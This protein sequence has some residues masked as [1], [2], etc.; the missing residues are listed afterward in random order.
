MQR[1]EYGAAGPPILPTSTQR[2]SSSKYRDQPAIAGSWVGSCVLSLLIAVT[3]LF[4]PWA[5][6]MMNMTL[7]AF[8]TH[9]SHPHLAWFSVELTAC[10]VGLCGI[11]AYYLFR[12]R[13]TGELRREIW[14]I[15]FF[16]TAFIGWFLGVVLG[17]L[18]YSLYMKRFYDITS[19]A[20]YPNVDPAKSNGQQLLDMGRVIFT[21]ESHL[22]FSK[23]F[24]FT[25][26]DVYCVAPIVSGDSRF[27][28]YDFWAVG[29]NCCK[30]PG[31]FKCGDAL[32]PLAHAGTRL[33]DEGQAAQ[34]RLAVHQ[35][36]ATFGIRAEHP[37]FV[38]WVEDPI[39]E[40]SH[41]QDAG[42]K[43]CLQCSFT[44]FGMQLCLVVLASG[45]S[46]L[47]AA[48]LLK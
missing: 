44:L 30:G 9:Y 20:M 48:M 4:A 11:R 3:C 41:L 33:L 10:L 21:K 8:S 25:D 46:R 2:K 47:R 27:A 13:T 12:R 18:D 39:S 22:D 32:N 28:S 35:A 43:M 36:E 38:Q 26:S 34:F 40:M 42:L 45:S 15:F 24:T 5:I 14:H 37:L 23:A 6:F 7:L 19:L 16:T 1:H 17:L 29:T 31:D